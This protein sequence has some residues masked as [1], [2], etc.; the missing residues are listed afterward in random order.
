MLKIAS[1]RLAMA[2]FIVVS[3]VVGAPA[4]AEESPAFQMPLA[5]RIWAEVNSDN[6][7]SFWKTLKHRDQAEVYYAIK[8]F[9]HGMVY[10]DSRGSEV[11]EDWLF[12]QFRQEN[13]WRYGALDPEL[14]DKVSANPSKVYRV[15]VWSRHS[16]QPK[17]EDPTSLTKGLRPDNVIVSDRPTLTEGRFAGLAQF[18]HGRLT[19]PQA[20]KT[21]ADVEALLAA[22]PNE[23]M[24]SLAGPNS[25][26]VSA[27]EAADA[28]EI[29]PLSHTPVVFASIGGA[30]LLANKYA[31]AFDFVAEADVPSSR[32]TLQS[33]IESTSLVMKL[34][35]AWSLW[36]APANNRSVGIVESAGGVGTVGSYFHLALRDPL[37]GSGNLRPQCVSGWGTEALNHASAMASAATGVRGG[38][39]TVIERDAT[40][41]PGVPFVGGAAPYAFP[42]FANMCFN[43]SLPFG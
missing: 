24:A 33:R 10:V 35:Q 23:A 9:K 8:S 29:Q 34:N 1:T 18:T 43:Q 19:R 22:L 30:V 39:F 12:D 15:A 2:A 3:L 11:G 31:H 7:V 4:L 40:S 21:E 38:S 17:L 6:S 26:V 32:Y 16:Y 36:T 25:L 13:Y 20:L 28:A 37:V 41:T 14:Y 27:L 5:V 42:V